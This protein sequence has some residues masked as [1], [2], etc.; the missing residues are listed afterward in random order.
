M[1]DV[2]IEGKVGGSAA[3]ALE[4]HARPL[5]DRPGVRLLAIV[6]LAH[7]ERVQPAP[8]SDKSASVKLRISGMEIP[9]R[10]QE[11]AI[12]EAMRALYVQRTAMGTIEE[13][14]EIVLTEATLKRT[15]GLLVEIE[16][17]KLRAGLRHWEQYARRVTRVEQLTA[18]EGLHEMATIADGLADV[19]ERAAL[20]DGE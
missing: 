4:P 14:G 19:L 17:A 9:S 1:T 6:E 8:D 12:R 13:D 7:V 15:A 3:A 16:L 5:Y 2:K 20:D 10:D 18:S 11:G